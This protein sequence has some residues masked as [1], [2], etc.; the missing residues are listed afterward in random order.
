MYYHPPN[1]ASLQRPKDALPVAAGGT[2]TSSSSSG[3]LYGNDNAI[4][5]GGADPTECI[6]LH[7]N[8]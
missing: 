6:S 5:A 8:V 2:S 1:H 4:G 7:S 3:I